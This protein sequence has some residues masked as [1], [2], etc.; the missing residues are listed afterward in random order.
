MPIEATEDQNQTGIPPKA[1]D[2]SGPWGRIS[3][4]PRSV[5]ILRICK[6]MSSEELHS[7]P[8]RVLSSWHLLGVG[9]N[10]EELKI[11]A[12]PDLITVIGRGLS[13]IADALDQSSLELIAE[14][15][16]NHEISQNDKIVIT[17]I[18]FESARISA[19][20]TPE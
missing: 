5:D 4:T 6:G 1:D 7:Y 3:P 10:Q 16:T 14:S 9:Q 17:R 11:E 2:W 13:R 15:L 20:E 8:Y 12:G 18:N 19:Q